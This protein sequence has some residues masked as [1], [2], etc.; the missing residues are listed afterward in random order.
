MWSIIVSLCFCCAGYL[1]NSSYS[2]W[3][4]SPVATSQETH[5]IADL[6]FPTVTV[7]PPKNSHTALNYD[8]MKADNN[9]LTREDREDLKNK[10]YK[11]FIES[12][13]YDFIRSMVAAANSE[14]IKQTFDGFQSVPISYAGNR[15]FEIRMWNNNGTWHT[16]GFGEEQEKSYYDEDKYYRLV[17]EL[18]KDF[19]EKIGSGTLVIQLEVDT[20]EEEDWQEEVE[21]WEGS[22]YT[23][24]SEVLTWKEAEAHCMKGGGHLASVQSAGENQDV[25]GIFGENTQ[26]VWLGGTSNVGDRIMKW[27]DGT[28]WSYTNLNFEDRSKAVL[29]DSCVAIPF[30]T[31]GWTLNS[32]TLRKPFIC[33]NPP[34]KV[35]RGN[36]SLTLQYTKENLTFT[37]FT[38][39]YRYKVT[40][41]LLES[42]GDRK[43]TGF[44]LSWFLQD[45]NQDSPTTV[46]NP[47][48]SVPLYNKQLV[49]R[50]VQLA[51]HA[52][53]QNITREEIINK[54]M[55]EKAN[56]I[57]KGNIQYAIMCLGNQISP[58]Y[59]QVI[60]QINVGLNDQIDG[61]IYDEDYLTGYMLFSTLIYC[62]ESVALSQFLY[63]LISI[64][65]PRTII[66]ATV[67]TLQSENVRESSNKIKLSQFYLALDK[68]FHFQLGKILLASASPSE[69][70]AMLA[71]DWP[72]FTH[73]SKDIDKCLRGDSCQ[74]VG[75]L[76]QTLGKLFTDILTK[77]HPFFSRP[78]GNSH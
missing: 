4:E 69:L 63:G 15:G 47:L 16:P 34:N 23:G 46:F 58:R 59:Y 28:P 66:Q 53:T 10:A 62:S 50:M 14:N 44:R 6:D 11:L 19:Y 31:L 41:N 26:Q 2:A 76:V 73:Y 29:D 77:L 13:H 54:T 1:I 67:N 57:A 22:K 3:L 65:S 20:R 60:D 27:S 35:L 9:S 45:N 12:S 75:N 18:P 8:L 71:K 43:M 61:L 68:I 48:T 7:C 55:L 52:R 17:L 42:L 38:V 33:Q 24:N 70:K 64:Q 37:T 49:V 39:R 72:Y 30:Y 5:P 56:L 40:R 32:C 51:R 36:T 74:G 21:Y 78:I 25:Y